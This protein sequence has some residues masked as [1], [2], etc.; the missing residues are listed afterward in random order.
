MR[1]EYL[2]V[3]LRK[4]NSYVRYYVVYIGIWSYQYSRC[5]PKW[6]GASLFN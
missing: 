2:K 1:Y 4:L 5:H 6:L 3:V